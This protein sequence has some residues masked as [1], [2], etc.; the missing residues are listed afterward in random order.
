MTRAVFYEIRVEG[1]IG[2]SWSPWSEGMTIRHKAGGTTALAGTL[3]DEAALH[4]V[5][6]RIRDLGLPLV[7][8]RWEECFQRGL[9]VLRRGGA[10]VH[11][12]APQSFSGFLR[13]V[14]KL[15][16]FNLLPSGK[17]IKGYGTHRIDWRLLA[18]D[19][20][21]LFELLE[22]GKIRPIIAETFPLL[23]AARANALLESG[24]VT[25]NVVLL[26]PEA[27]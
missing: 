22:N 8:V 6:A 18:E 5:L 16:W 26:A 14:A 24:Q 21:T 7:E 17:S 15:I 4:G 23:E 2:D 12:G 11:Y 10:L 13:L 19:W 9:A 27:L 1:H 25:G 3:A 20:S